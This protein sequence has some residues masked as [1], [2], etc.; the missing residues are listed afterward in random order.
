MAD[1]NK[2]TMEQFV[3][4]GIS[5]LTGDRVEISRPMTKEEADFRLKREKECRRKSRFH[6]YTRLRVERRLPVQLRIKFDE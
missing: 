1:L 3:I 2:I 4:T 6:A 5:F